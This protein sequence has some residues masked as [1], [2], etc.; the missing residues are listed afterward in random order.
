MLNNVMLYHRRMPL[1]PT[2]AAMS[3]QQPMSGHVMAPGQAFQQ[4]PSQQQQ[5]QQHESHQQHQQQ[6]Q[7]QQN[8]A[9]GTITGMLADFSR[10]LGERR[11]P[12]IRRIVF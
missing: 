12:L 1:S 10:A 4:Q 11:S 5:L 8:K 6:S 7:Q 2:T 9:G 3:G